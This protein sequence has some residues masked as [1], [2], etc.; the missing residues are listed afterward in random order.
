MPFYESTFIVRQDVASQQVEALAATLT[1]LVQDNG[2]TVVKTEHWGL[3]SLAYR[4]KKNR[5]GHYV[6][7]GLDAPAAAVKEMERN[8]GINED[9]LRYMTVRVAE[10]DANPT[11]MMQAKQGKDD[12][13]RDD[14]F[15]DD[16]YREGGYRARDRGAEGADV[17]EVVPPGDVV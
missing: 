5:K 11:V 9:V 15:R 1:Q 7:F 13:R 14:R 17:V 2:G 4:V 6:M 10:M 8:L 16:R 12:R 3:K